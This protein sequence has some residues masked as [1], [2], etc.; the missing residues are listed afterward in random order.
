MYIY[1]FP[2]SGTY[3]V[4]SANFDH[5]TNSVNVKC[6]FAINA[7][8]LACCI[9]FI[10]TSLRLTFDGLIQHSLH[11]SAGAIAVPK[12]VLQRELLQELRKVVFDAKVY[13]LNMDENVADLP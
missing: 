4:Q 7:P 13:D 10:N 6:I 8:A 3:S 12:T 11:Q 9:I 2:F 5:L 1:V